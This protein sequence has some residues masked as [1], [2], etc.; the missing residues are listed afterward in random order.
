MEGCLRPPAERWL[1]CDVVQNS[2]ATFEGDV[3]T[4]KRAIAS[5]KYP[6]VLV[7]HSYAGSIITE[8]GND[9]KVRSLVYIAAFGPKEGESS[10]T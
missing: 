4:T 7:G 5:A 6:V 10:K 9:P 8:A 1:R 2:T 3:A